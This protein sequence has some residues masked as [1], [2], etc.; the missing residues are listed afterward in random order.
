M[1]VNYL[2]IMIYPVDLPVD[3]GIPPITSECAI[4]REANPL[5]SRFSVRL[6]R[7]LADSLVGSGGT[8]CLALLL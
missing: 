1:N 3:L 5:K 7:T 8:T 4:L 2:Y 6:Q